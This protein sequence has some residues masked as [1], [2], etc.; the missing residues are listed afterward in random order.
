MK[1]FPSE[2]LDRVTDAIMVLD[3]DWK[4]T[5]LNTPAAE[6]LRAKPDEAHGRRL[7]EMDPS[8]KGTAWEENFVQALQN[9]KP[10]IFEAFSPISGRC[11]EVRVFPSREGL[12]V[13]ARDVTERRRFENELRER[14]HRYREMIESLPQL[15]WA[16]GPDGKCDYLNRQWVEFTGI[17]ESEQ[18]GHNWLKPLHPDDRARVLQAWEKAVDG[19]GPY[20]IE[21]RIRRADG[22]YRW[23]K[24]RGVPLRDAENRIIRWFGT[25]TDIDDQKATEHSIREH[26]QRLRELNETLEERVAERTALAEKRTVELRQ[27]IEELGQTEHRERADLARV[28]HDQLQQLLVAAKFRIRTLHDPGSPLDLK[29]RTQQLEALIGRAIDELRSLAVDLSPPVLTDVG[30]AAGLEWLC[31]RMEEKHRLRVGL[32]VG[33]DCEPGD[34]DLKHFLFQSA[35]ELLINVATHAEVSEAELKVSKDDAGYLNLVVS[36]AGRGLDPA[37][38]K[39]RAAASGFGLFNIQQRIEIL[40]GRFEILSS[41]LRGCSV[42]IS[43]PTKAARMPVPVLD[44]LSKKAPEFLAKP[45]HEGARTSVLIVDDHEILREGM[46]S[47]LESIIDIEVIGQ[48]GDG[49]AAVEMTRRLRPDVVLMDITMPVMNGVEATRSIKAEMPGCHVIALSMHEKRDMAQAMRAAGASA[50]ISKDAP[51]DELSSVIRKVVRS[52]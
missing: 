27:L 44:S 46:V 36:D 12:T 48:A 43:A 29:T 28:L 15:V 23:F 42:A 22:V 20:S 49:A 52:E 21:C 5:Y 3:R 33:A 24:S 31:R 17:P 14:E 11:F 38:L 39:E 45:A 47:L 16:S 6:E 40:G 32:K 30:L 4:F 50:Y 26:E 37:R 35:R 7:W 13:Y 10:A 34:D 8:F 9:Q 1:C 18:L 2:I 51:W 41:P 25:S 19:R